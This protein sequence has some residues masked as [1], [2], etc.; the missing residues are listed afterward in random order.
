[1]SDTAADVRRLHRR[2]DATIRAV[3][4]AT[5]IAF[6]AYVVNTSWSR[7]RIDALERRVEALEQK[8]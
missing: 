6:M 1:M 4:L 3:F 5:F 8:R 2:I 7:D